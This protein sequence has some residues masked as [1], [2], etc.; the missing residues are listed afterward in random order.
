MKVISIG[1]L[2]L[3]VSAGLVGLAVAPAA[4]VSAAPTIN[5]PCNPAAL[6][7][8]ITTANGAGGGTLNL[9]TGCTYTLTA[10]NNSTTIPMLGVSA[11]GLP[12]VTKPI[13]ITG[14]NAT[15]TR[16]TTAPDFRL[17]EVDGPGGN[18]TL[19]GIGLTEGNAVVGGALFNVEGSVTLNSV[20]VLNNTAAM[21]GGGLASG[22]VDPTHLGPIGTLTLNSTIVSGNTAAGWRWR[23]HPEPRRH[24]D[25]Q[26]QHRVQQH[27]GRRWRWHRQWTRQRR[28]RWEQHPE[29]QSEP[30]D[31]QHLKRWTHGRRGWDR[32]RRGRDAQFQPG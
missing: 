7:A 3:G 21:G 23:R 22:V 17:F 18:L 9:A 30:G 25:A 24:D 15:I 10:V 13:T 29:P 2:A 14:Q 27:L 31:R 28:N 16:S 11:N 6:I 5:V 4:L 32:Q 26:Q 12:V 20:R 8:A 1:R 19:N